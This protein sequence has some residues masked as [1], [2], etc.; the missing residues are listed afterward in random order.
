VP[1]EPEQTYVGRLESWS[2]RWFQS[3]RL[4]PD[5]LSSSRLASWLALEWQ[6]KGG[7]RAVRLLKPSSS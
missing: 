7:L 5:R 3:V 4:L 2:A 1:D 6:S